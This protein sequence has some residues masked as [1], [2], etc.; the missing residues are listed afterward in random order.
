MRSIKQKFINLWK[1]LAESTTMKH[2]CSSINVDVA[3]CTYNSEKYLDQCLQSIQNFVPF[4]RLIIV[5][6]YS[7]DRTVKIAKKYG[8]EIYFENVGVGYARQLAI[9][10]SSA[11][12][13]LFVDSDVVF[14][15]GIWFKKCVRLFQNEK[16][17]AGAIGV[18]TPAKLPGWRMKYVEFWWRKFPAS[19]R[20]YFHNVYFLR[21]KAIE[22]I[23]IPYLLGAFEHIYIKRY[24]ESKGWNVYIV[25]G[26]GVHYY[27]FP[28][29]K[30]AWI[31]AG[32]RVF[33]YAKIRHLPVIVINKV[34]AAPLKALPPAIAYS[35]PTILFH[36]LIYWFRYLMGLLKP[37]DYIML[38]RNHKAQKDQL[39]LRTK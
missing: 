18:D 34:L 36:N 4:N 7:T 9:E 38:K 15:D 11:P 6:H 20:I 19:R 33:G 24:V 14:N 12:F 35:D 2:Q 37:Y 30:G 23:K 8:A 3:V 27:D 26:N 31:G 10:H 28:D 21:K 1:L 13:L 29:W 32:E 5:D 17:K 39:W 16:L 25:Q 22:G